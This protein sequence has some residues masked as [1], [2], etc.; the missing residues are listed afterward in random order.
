MISDRFVLIY[1]L[2]GREKNV[3]K[4]NHNKNQYLSLLEFEFVS[5]HRNCFINCEKSCT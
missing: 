2:F 3:E 5:N 4:L 1:I